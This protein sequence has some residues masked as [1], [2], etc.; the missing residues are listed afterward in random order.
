ME[1]LT[2]NQIQKRYEDYE[3]HTGIIALNRAIDK[4][5]I[6]GKTEHEL[7]NGNIARQWINSNWETKH[8]ELV[9]MRN[10]IIEREFADLKP[11]LDR[12]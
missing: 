7:P 5:L 3:G 8:A 2:L 1:T 11:L 9:T 12:S 6:E 10:R 4:V